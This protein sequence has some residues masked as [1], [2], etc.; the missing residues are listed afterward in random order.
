[1]FEAQY[2]VTDTV[3][4]VELYSPWMPRGGDYLQ[5][6]IDTAQVENG[7]LTVSLRHKD[8]EDAGEGAAVGSSG[9]GDIEAGGQITKN[10]TT[11]LDEVVR[12]AF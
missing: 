5:Y 10:V 3:A 8:S 7:K 12:Y 6:T 11:G 1:M 4:G 9:S 2:L